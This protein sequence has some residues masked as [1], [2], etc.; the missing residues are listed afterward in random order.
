MLCLQQASNQTGTVNDVTSI[1]R[2]ARRIK[3]DLY[4]VVDAVQY[5]PHGPIDVEDIGAD[6]Y[7]FGPYKAY[8]VKGIGFAHI[9]ERLANLPHEN[10]LLKADTNWVLGSPAH[11]MFA[12]WSKPEAPWSVSLLAG[13]CISIAVGMLMPSSSKIGLAFKI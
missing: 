4:V 6:A 11:A 3:P 12:T 1:I 8:G 10:L 2:E 9:S 5:A 7:A 13:A